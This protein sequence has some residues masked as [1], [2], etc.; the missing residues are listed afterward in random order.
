MSTAP[1]MFVL[2]VFAFFGNKS[3]VTE[4]GKIRCVRNYWV[5]HITIIQDDSLG[6]RLFFTALKPHQIWCGRW[7][8]THVGRFLY[9]KINGD[10]LEGKWMR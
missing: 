3:P 7:E 1:M 8:F 9:V 5:E 4:Y 10:T 6:H 2:L